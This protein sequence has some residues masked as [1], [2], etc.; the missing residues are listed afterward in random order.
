MKPERVVARAL[1]AGTGLL[2]LTAP[3]AFWRLLPDGDAAAGWAAVVAAA[4]AVEAALLSAWTSQ[5]VVELQEDAQRPNVQPSFDVRSRYQIVQFRLTNQ[6]QSPAFDVRLSWKRTLTNLDEEIVVFGT[7]GSLP[8]LRP[9]ESA[10]RALGSSQQF[11]QRFDDT[12]YSGTISFLDASGTHYS[13]PFVVSAEHE[14]EA[15]LHDSEGPKTAYELQQIPERLGAIAAELK[16][17]RTSAAT[18]SVK[19]PSVDETV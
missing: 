3:F 2:A 19:E 12:T 9:G 11:F 6:G 13:T 8:V 10:S 14:R 15:L 18:G 17:A 5:R 1:L 4:L 16:F 7:Q